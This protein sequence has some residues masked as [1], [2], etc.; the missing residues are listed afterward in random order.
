MGRLIK[1]LIF[2]A[3]ILLVVF[4]I[5]CKHEPFPYVP[6]KSV[7]TV[8]THVVT[9][10]THKD[11]VP[12]VVGSP[13]SKDTV[14]FTNTIL[15]LIISNCASAHCHDAISHH[16]GHNLTTYAGIRAIVSPG[17][18]SSSKLYTILSSTKKKMPPAGPLSAEQKNE[19]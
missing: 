8:T 16:S 9:D 7:D 13:C 1:K 17:N 4:V 3:G 11:T 10:T 14:Y 12:Q 5:S 6:K 2:L 15:P 18:P 19:I